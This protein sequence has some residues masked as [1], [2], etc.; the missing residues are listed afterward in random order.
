M[1]LNAMNENGNA[2][3]SDAQELVILQRIRKESGFD[4]KYEVVVY[5]GSLDINHQD[6]SIKITGNLT[7]IKGSITTPEDEKGNSRTSPNQQKT[8]EIE[9][10]IITDDVITSWLVTF[11]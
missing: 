6:S 8:A 10:I 7:N 2:N 5:E 3:L 4:V 9:E 11:L 1:K